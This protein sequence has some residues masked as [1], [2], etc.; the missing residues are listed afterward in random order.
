MSTVNIFRGGGSLCCHAQPLRSPRRSHPGTTCLRRGSVCH[1]PASPGLCNHG[2]PSRAMSTGLCR[3]LA[4]GSGTLCAPQWYFFHRRRARRPAR[5]VQGGGECGARRRPGEC[6]ARWFPLPRRRHRGA[7]A[8]AGRATRRGTVV[9]V[10]RWPL[11]PVLDAK[12]WDQLRW[13]AGL[14]SRHGTASAVLGSW[15]GA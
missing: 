3:S 5:G 6:S 2:G 10:V 8:L 12:L 4:T 9:A 13:W 15:F 14:G 11:E 1:R 7:A